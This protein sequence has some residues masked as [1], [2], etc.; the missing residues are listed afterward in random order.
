MKQNLIIKIRIQHLINITNPGLP[1]PSPLPD[2]VCIVEWQIQS[3][4]KKGDIYPLWLVFCLLYCSHS[5]QQLIEPVLN[6][7][8]RGYCDKGSNKGHVGTTGEQHINTVIVSH[9]KPCTCLPG[10]Q[11]FKT[12]NRISRLLGRGRHIILLPRYRTTGSR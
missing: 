7:L 11:W 5:L 12:S 10:V 3:K 8:A 9:F 1:C 4:A 2:R 6:P